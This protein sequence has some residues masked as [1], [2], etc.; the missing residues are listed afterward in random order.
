MRRLGTAAPSSG[1]RIEISHRHVASC[2]DRGISSEFAR[3]RFFFASLANL[4]LHCLFI[5]WLDAIEFMTA[6][7]ITVRRSPRDELRHKPIRT[8]RRRAR[9]VRAPTHRNVHRFIVA[10]DAR[11]TA[12]A[13]T[14]VHWMTHLAAGRTSPRAVSQRA[15]HG[16]AIS[17]DGL[18][19]H[20]SHY[21]VTGARLQRHA[22]LLLFTPDG[23]VARAHAGTFAAIQFVALV[24]AV[25]H[26]IIA[27]HR[28]RT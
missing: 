1:R 17:V 22:L 4:T 3:G 9:A 18:H 20:G 16:R 7:A 2:S 25:R 27:G 10:V 13:T 14:L 12:L 24:S 26:G 8:R 5:Y 28:T 15:L 19:F 6:W 21:V 23:G 11:L